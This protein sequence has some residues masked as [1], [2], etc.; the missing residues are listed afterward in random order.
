MNINY[1]LI[2][3][4][5]HWE[6]PNVFLLSFPLKSTKSHPLSA[7]YLSDHDRVKVSNNINVSYVIYKK[8]LGNVFP[9]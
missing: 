4:A 3:E 8:V 5:Y 2:L 6:L 9:Q 1:N 7:N